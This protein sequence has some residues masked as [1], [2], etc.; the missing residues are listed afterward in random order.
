VILFRYIHSL[1]MAAVVVGITLSKWIKMAIERDLILTMEK[2]MEFKVGE[3]V[4]LAADIDTGPRG[5]DVVVDGHTY[6]PLEYFASNR[7]E[8]KKL[9]DGGCVLGG[10]KYSDIPFNDRG[11]G[12]AS[13]G[14]GDTMSMLWSDLA[15]M[16][17]IIHRDDEEEEEEE[18]GE[19]DEEEE[20]EEEKKEEGAQVDE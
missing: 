1:A 10:D 6:S 19:G 7:E 8:F 12:Y 15:T 2:V 4:I 17:P 5:M 18:E 13:L 3:S 20:E 11:D 16:P 14:T 9:A